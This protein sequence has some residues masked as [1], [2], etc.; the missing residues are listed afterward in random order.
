MLLWFLPSLVTAPLPSFFNEGLIEEGATREQLIQSYFYQG[1]TYAHILACLAVNHAVKLSLKTLKRILKRLGLMRRTP[2]TEGVA[3]SAVTAIVQELEQSGQCIGYRA[4]HKRL[5]NQGIVIGKNNVCKL[6]QEIDARGVKRRIHRRLKRRQYVN[7]G[8]NFA[9]HIDGYDKLK[10][11]GFAIHGAIDGFSRRIL[12]LEVGTSNNDPNIVLN[13][14]VDTCIQLGAIPCVVR[15]DH[16]TE[17]VLV[18]E[19]HKALRANFNDE[20]AADNSFLKGK[21]SA[22]QRIERWWGI[23]RVQCANFWI[24]LFKDMI[25]IGLLD[26]G[27]QFHIHTLRFCFMDLI[28]KDIHRVAIEWNQH[29]IQA[30]KASEGPKGKPNIMY[31][32]PELYGATNSSF[33]VRK[34]DLMSVKHALETANCLPVQQDPDFIALVTELVPNWKVPEN[35]NAALD[36]YGDI[37]QQLQTV[38]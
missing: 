31:F 32:T 15:S 37:I 36:L 1:Y 18:E 26:N 6:M 9:W 24:N 11:Y 33:P 5:Q 30:R 7:P 16:G 34:V 13:H 27:N 35:V 4:M 28:E 17:N 2:F 19:L 14:Y 29:T 8:P 38:L 10:P 21:S 3:T 25:S 20:Y 12:W 22:N 23:L